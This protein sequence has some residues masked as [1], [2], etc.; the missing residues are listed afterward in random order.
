M[1][2]DPM[3][4][5][6]PVGRSERRWRSCVAR[7]S[8]SVSALLAAWLAPDVAHA[9]NRYVA[10]TGNDGGN[11]CTEEAS[12]CKT[13]R[14][15]IDAMSGGDTLIIGDG[16][17][18]ESITGMPSGSP[19]AYT[20][21]RAANDW[22]VLIDGSGFPDNYRFGINVTGNSYVT[23][24]GFRVKMNQA[25]GNNEPIIV[26]E[27]DHIKIQRC[28]A[29]HAPTD[30]NAASIDIGPR[31]SYI[32]IEESFAFGG[33]RYQFVIYQADHVVV[34]RSV[35]RS[36]HWTGT[37]QCAGFVNYDS[38]HTTWQNNIVLDSD[39]TH[40]RGKLYGGFWNENKDDYAPDTSQTLAGNIVLNVN[41]FY[42]ADLDWGISGT[43]NV[44]DMVIWGCSGGYFGNQGPGVTASVN[45]TRLTIGGITGRYDGPNDG[46]AH[47][48]G[49]SI[50]GKVQNSLTSSV[51]AKC[52]SLGVADHTASDFNVFSGNGANYGGRTKAAAGPNDKTDIDVLNGGGLRHLPH[53][54]VGSPLKTAGKDGGQAG[55]E[56]MYK[57]GAEG[58]LDGEPGWDTVTAEP[59]WPFPN[60]DQ[61]KKDMGAYD[62]PGAPGARGFA[63]GKSLDGS[64]QTL[65]KYVWE[66][67]GH[68]IPK[69]VY[70]GGVIEPPPAGGSSGGPNGGGAKSDA[71]SS[72]EE[73]GGCGCRAGS[74]VGRGGAVV[75]GLALALLV[76]R[77]RRRAA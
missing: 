66:F 42:A 59:L 32:L 53:I 29:S 44:S 9:A 74:P 40:C 52:E 23:I 4:P 69:E 47:G 27:S 75:G 2:G 13:I 26:T 16:T 45:A 8:V 24:R 3:R 77:R 30:G 64:D 25:N 51:L 19:G 54:D 28:S 73:D 35:A 58:T 68:P 38:I 17:Y 55:A 18:A 61:I 49:W 21:I 22:G 39:T 20:T 37:L 33:G 60:E 71:L 50:F 62:G 31:A 14:H 1:T 41:A 7:A 56:I 15:G 6:S 46:A 70:A 65:T 76:A 10:T 43:R 72:G 57:I 48:T 36:D 5:S 67:L 63:T 12:P 34:R 11:D